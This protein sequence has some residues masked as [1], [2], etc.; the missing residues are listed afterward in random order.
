MACIFQST[1]PARG[2]TSRWKC[3]RLSATFQSTLPA[4]GATVEAVNATFNGRADFNPRSPH[5][6]RL[7]HPASVKVV[8]YFN[9]RSP[10]G[11]RLPHF[12]ESEEE[13]AYFNPRS[14]HGERPCQRAC[15]T[16]ARTNFNPRSPHGERQYQRKAMRTANKISIHAPRTGSDKG[17]QRNRVHRRGISIH[18]PRTGSDIL[19]A[20][21]QI[22]CCYFNPRSP[23]G[24]RPRLNNMPSPFLTDF[25]PRSPH[26]ERLPPMQMC[27]ISRIF[28][29]TL[30]AR[31][32]TSA[33][34]L[35]A[36]RC[37]IS[38]HAPRTGSDDVALLVTQANRYFNPRSPHG[39]RPVGCENRQSR[40]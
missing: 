10:H 21:F 4:R 13:N 3:R 15:A 24:E 25:N 40:K 14:P 18:A 36:P 9:P 11:E 35:P 1:L 28:Q 20:E 8:R 5:G 12:R 6:E 38:I 23:H 30:P 33:C 31:G 29:S 22:C 7:L 27:G 37:G 17:G 2:A 19:G 26:G 39:E 34:R 16:N 32:A